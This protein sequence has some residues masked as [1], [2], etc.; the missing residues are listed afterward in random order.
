VLIHCREGQSRSPTIFLSHLVM[1]HKKTLSE[2]LQIL[3]SNYGESHV[4]LN[5][6][7]KQQ[8]MAFE[9]EK[10]GISSV[11]LVGLSER[12]KR[13]PKWQNDFVN[14][15]SLL[16]KRPRSKSLNDASPPKK[17]R[18]EKSVTSKIETLSSDEK[19]LESLANNTSVLGA[20][21]SAQSEQSSIRNEQEGVVSRTVSEM[22]AT[23]RLFNEISE[24][25]SEE[26][27]ANTQ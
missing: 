24:F 13:A 7:F 25:P 23:S 1:H 15:D 20:I 21:S 11:D 17:S 3:Y 2:A 5:I 9:K 27:T 12:P 10:L 8:I 26:V 4:S 19:P 14:S 6:G 22:T 18:K 16:K